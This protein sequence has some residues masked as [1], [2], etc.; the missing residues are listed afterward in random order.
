MTHDQQARGLLQFASANARGSGGQSVG[1]FVNARERGVDALL[2]LGLKTLN[3]LLQRLNAP[4]V[5]QRNQRWHNE[6]G[7]VFGGHGL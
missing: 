1:G 2:A 6:V 3:A 7:E 5:G 4:V